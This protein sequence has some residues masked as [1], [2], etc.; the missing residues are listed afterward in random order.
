MSPERFD[1]LRA[2]A[3]A[4]GDGGPPL[5]SAGDVIEC[6]EEISRLAA[7]V[8]VPGG[9]HC[10]KC[11]FHLTTSILYAKSGN[12]GVD[13]KIPDPCPNDGTPL[14]PDTWEADAR[15][16]GAVNAAISKRSELGFRAPL[17]AKK[18]WRIGLTAK[19][20]YRTHARY[21]EGAAEIIDVLPSGTNHIAD[22]DG[23]L[24]LKTITGEVILEPADNWVTA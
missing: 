1:E 21:Y 12:V 10:P 20:K 4:C 22:K 6:L 15:A 17:P 16:M 19:V 23:V 3:M 7:M 13:R 8:Y 24:K 5:L 9:W 11:K 18:D 14:E 2:N